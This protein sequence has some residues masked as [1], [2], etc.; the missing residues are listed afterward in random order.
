MLLRSM[1]FLL[2]LWN[3]STETDTPADL[4]GDAEVELMDVRPRQTR[5]RAGQRDGAEIGRQLAKLI[6]QPGSVAKL[7]PC[8]PARYR[9]GSCRSR[10]SA[11]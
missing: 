9:R 2:T 1:K 8:R 3:H 4:V 10:R 6:S 7:Q 11:A 5:I